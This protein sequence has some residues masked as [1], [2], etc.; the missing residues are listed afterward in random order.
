[1]LT[2]LGIILINLHIRISLF[3]DQLKALLK[4]IVRLQCK[5]EKNADIDHIVMKLCPIALPVS[6]IL[7]ELF[8][9]A[10]FIFNTR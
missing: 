4:S 6:P 8:P 5:K 10:G 1:M 9:E 2:F 3:Q 7:K